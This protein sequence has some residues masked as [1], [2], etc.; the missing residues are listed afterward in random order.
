MRAGQRC[1]VAATSWPCWRERER[2][3]LPRD[4]RR[5]SKRTCWPPPV[6]HRRTASI[7]ASLAC[8]SR[9]GLTG[10]RLASNRAGRVVD[11]IRRKRK[12]RYHREMVAA[13]HYCCWMKAMLELPA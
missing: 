10:T 11:M 1:S 9:L 2:P 5:M 3:A 8:R 4:S 7:P 12:G 6:K 13:F